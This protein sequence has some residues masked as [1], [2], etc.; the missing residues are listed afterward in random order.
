MVPQAGLAHM[1]GPGA[2]Q[3]GPLGGPILEPFWPGA[4]QKGLGFMVP[5]ADLAYISLPGGPQNRAKI[6]LFRGSF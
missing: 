5:Q 2:A 1:A 3:I 6:P 4:V